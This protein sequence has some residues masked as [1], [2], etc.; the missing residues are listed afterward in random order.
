MADTGTL[1]NAAE[2]EALDPSLFEFVLRRDE[3]GPP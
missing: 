2:R 1:G 3:E